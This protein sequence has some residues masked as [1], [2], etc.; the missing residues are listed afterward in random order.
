M[1]DDGLDAVKARALV[2]HEVM[3][4]RQVEHLIYI[5]AAGEQK[6]HDRSDLAGGTVFQRQHRA[7][8]LAALDCLIGVGKIREGHELG[9]REHTLC[10]HVGERAL[11]AAVGHAHT[12]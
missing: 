10:R 1:A 6:I 12:L 9:L 7:V 3:H 2:C 4:N 8:K 11:N 5:Q